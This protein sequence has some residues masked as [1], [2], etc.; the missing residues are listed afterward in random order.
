MIGPMDHTCHS[1]TD[2]PS[3]HRPDDGSDSHADGRQ[4]DAPDVS[5]P[6]VIVAGPDDA[7]RDSVMDA[8][9][10]AGFPV[11]DCECRD[12]GSEMCDGTADQVG[13]RDVI[14]F[15]FRQNDR[16]TGHQCSPQ[17][18]EAF[19]SMRRRHPRNPM[20]VEVLDKRTFRDAD[21]LLGAHVVTTPASLERLR[22]VVLHAWSAP[23]TIIETLRRC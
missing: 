9:D 7:L 12:D 19:L 15:S 10:R 8:L 3:A 23:D 2:H 21:L 18:R 11:V 22:E 17:R 13:R 5:N 20:V 6:R 16:R 4:E 14:F 1:R